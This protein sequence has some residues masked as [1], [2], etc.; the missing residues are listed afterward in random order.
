MKICSH[1]IFERMSDYRKDEAIKHTRNCSRRRQPQRKAGVSA[2]ES[3]CHGQAC[4]CG[5]W[6]NSNGYVGIDCNYIFVYL[7]VYLYICL[8]RSDLLAGGIQ[9]SSERERVRPVAQVDA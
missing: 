3:W 7:F 2:V 4:R 5:T 9:L 1:A 6:R 8:L